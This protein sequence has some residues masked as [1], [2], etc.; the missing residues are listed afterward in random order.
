MHVH[1]PRGV[2]VVLVDKSIVDH[3][4]PGA[5]TRVPSPSAPS[6]PA[7]S[8]I[9]DTARRPIPAGVGIVEGRS[10]DPARVVN[11]HINDVGIGGLDSDVGL[12]TLISRDHILLWSGGQLTGLLRLLPQPLHGV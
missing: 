2:E 5:P 10:P 6:M 7:D 12:A 11:R 1:N 4:G 3:D 9:D 8:A